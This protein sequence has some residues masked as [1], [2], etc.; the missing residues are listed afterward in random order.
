MKF[1]KIL[2][3]L[4]FAFFVLPAFPSSKLLFN[5]TNYKIKF[6]ASNYG[7]DKG[8]YETAILVEA[9]NKKTITFYD[10]DHSILPS[11]TWKNEGNI[12]ELEFKIINNKENKKTLFIPLKIKLDNKF[13]PG[14]MVFDLHFPLCGKTCIPVS[15]HFVSNLKILDKDYVTLKF[16][17]D[18]NKLANDDSENII[19]ILFL[20]LCGGFILNLM[21]CV[22]PVISLKIFSV[23]NM[24]GASKIQIKKNFFAVAAGVIF[25]FIIIGVSIATLKILGNYAGLGLHFQEPYFVITISLVLIIFAAYLAGELN[26]TPPNWLTAILYKKA[27]RKGLIG[28]FISGI[29]AT[30]L[31]TPCTAPLIGTAV[32][33]ALT[34]GVISIL[35]IF[36]SMG[37]GMSLPF[38]ILA[39]DTRVQKI[40]PTSGKWVIWFKRFLEILIYLAV[41]WLLYILSQLLDVQA[42][43]LLFLLCLLVKF[44]VTSDSQFLKYKF[45]K[46]TLFIL[47]IIGAY[48]LPNKYVKN[49]IVREKE[50]NEFWQKF[51]F[52][53]L[54]QALK[55]DKIIFVNITADWCITCKYNKFTVL[56]NNYIMNIF[57]KNQIVAL[58]GDYTSSNK[59]IN[60]FMGIHNKFAIP[61]DV[62]YSK[63][64]P[65]GIILPPILTVS[66]VMDAIRQA[67]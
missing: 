60:K 6:L 4:Y 36:F 53:A 39:F 9:K 59:E 55:A 43:I 8:Q 17:K 34:H 45:I 64:H 29:L 22:L 23:I 38:I 67:K 12:K 52:E 7:N 57:E 49:E 1:K 10:Q 42:A 65:E 47:I 16:I 54:D 26:L 2:F 66:K 3:F 25:T 5:E 40:I 41:I 33:F 24:S 50:I 18:F 28:S 32:T 27:N 13:K 63:K 11:L 58:R 37:L 14:K 19:W 48:Y 21:P 30:V 31:A 46:L 61:L 20:A 35:A 51:S 44:V 62:V 15:V 56:N